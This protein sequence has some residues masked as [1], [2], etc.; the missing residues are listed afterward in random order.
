MK[1]SAWH[2]AHGDHIEWYEPLF[3]GAY[4]R[5]YMSK[6]F[7]FSQDYPF[8][9]NAK[10]IVKGG[11]GYGMYESLSEEIE[12]TF[13]DYSIYPNCNHAIGFLTRGCIRNCQWCIVP[14][15]EGWIRAANTWENVKRSDSRD[16][17]FM[18]NNV[19]ACDWGR[20]Q[21]A[22]MVGQNVR[23]DFNQALDARLLDDQIAKVISGLKWIQYIRFA[24]DTSAMIPVIDKAVELLKRHGVRP[25]RLF[26]CALIQDTGEALE[27]IKALDKM[28][29][30][31]FAQPY[32][33]FTGWTEPTAEQRR[34]AR[35]CNNKF[36]FRAT[37]FE[38]Y[39]TGKDVTKCHY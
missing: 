31:V 5:V 30:E 8:A 18:D 23:I 38:N 14:K 11:T 7:T 24:C 36:V 28:G 35:W 33:D 10:E 37:T 16:I 32:R 22:G 13:P 17:V 3:G 15:K 2:K 19:L 4:D 25:K 39:S 20:E 12:Y 27:R 9:I 1:L 6:V 34:M 29:V 26:I 21:M